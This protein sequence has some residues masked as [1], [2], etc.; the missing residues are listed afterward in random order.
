MKLGKK[1]GLSFTILTLMLVGISSFSLIKIKTLSSLTEQLYLH[2]LAVSNLVRDINHGKDIPGFYPSLHRRET[3]EF[4]GGLFVGLEVDH[5]PAEMGRAVTNAIAYGVRDL[6]E[7]LEKNN[8][9]IESLRVS[10]G[11]GRSTVWNQM[12]ADVTG[13]RIEVPAVIDTE[14]MGNA[15]TG[16]TASGYF[17]S[18]QES[19]ES[20]VRIDK[21]HTP[22][23]IEHEKFNEGYNYYHQRCLDFVK[24]MSKDLK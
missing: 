9:P 10:G 21:T 22:D 15:C 17:S 18:L 11:Q 6:I 3:W 1:I 13:K 20:M 2:P 8:C 4:S 12:K 24:I 7:T 19:T 14:L 5:G 16:F 23:K